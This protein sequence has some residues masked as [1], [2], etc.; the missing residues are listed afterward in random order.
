MNYNEAVEFLLA[1]PDMERNSRGPQARTMSLEAMKALLLQIGSPEKNRK[2]V[3]VTGSKG[4]GSS[5]ALIASALSSRGTTL[6]YSSPHLHSYLERICLGLQPVSQA[7]FVSALGSVKAQILELHNSELGPISTFG[8]MTALFFKLAEM[9]NA[10]WQVVEVGMGGAFDATNVFDATDLVVITAISLEH[11]SI[12]G[13]TIAEIARNKSGLIKPGSTVI[14]A[15]QK[16]AS[17]KEIVASVCQEKG[18]KLV[19]VADSYHIETQSHTA[20]RQTFQVRHNGILREFSLSLLGEHQLQNATTAIA[21]IDALGKSGKIDICASL[22]RDSLE[23]VFVPGRLELTRM[24][25]PVVLDGAHN[26]DSA[27]ALVQALERHF[28]DFFQ[29]K[30]VFIL[31]TNSDKDIEA[32]LD[33]LR[34]AVGTLIASRSSSD[35]A[36]PPEKIMEQALKKQIKVELAPD[37]NHALARANELAQKERAICVTG[38][39]YLVAEAREV[40]MGKN[41]SWSLEKLRPEPTVSRFV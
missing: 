33:A 35:K 6:T 27:A 5:S 24:S 38:S 15:A 16:D 41:L 4:K 12:L 37:I 3:H 28:P 8:A 11:T 7:D 20:D 21:A 40:L 26:G 23:R 13:S 18:A 25:P 22:L 30:P 32:I 14:L 1:L 9:K 10:L 36:M 17:V 39:L 29:E 2:T 19:D 31:G 34:P